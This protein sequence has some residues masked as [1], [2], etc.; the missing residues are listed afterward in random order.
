MDFIDEINE[1]LMSSEEEEEYEGVVRRP[2]RNFQRSTVDDF[3][4]ADFLRYFRLRKN[5]FWR[6]HGMVCDRLRGDPRR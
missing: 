1:M 6:L 3:D 2:Y 5:A 4:D